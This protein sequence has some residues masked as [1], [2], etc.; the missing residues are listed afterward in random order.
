MHFLKSDE[1]WGRS[2]M[3]MGREAGADIAV[4][5]VRDY[6]NSFEKLHEGIY[7]RSGTLSTL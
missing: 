7:S 6:E 1:L 3:N 2:S 4:T 5:N